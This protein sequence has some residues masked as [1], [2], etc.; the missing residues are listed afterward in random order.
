[1][2]PVGFEPT[3]LAGKRPQTYTLDRAVSGTGPL[4]VTVR[5]IEPVSLNK[6]QNKRLSS[7]EGCKLINTNANNPVVITKGKVITAIRSAQ[8][9]GPLCAV[10]QTH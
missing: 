9:K 5:N 7:D 2:P 4:H 3:I 8:F 6:P 10:F 1:M